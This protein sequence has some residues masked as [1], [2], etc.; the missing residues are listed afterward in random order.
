MM[1]MKMIHNVM[2][3]IRCLWR[4][5]HTHT[6][7]HTHTV[8]LRYVACSV[9]IVRSRTKATELVGTALIRNPDYKSPHRRQGVI[10]SVM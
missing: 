5:T 2:R 7:T 8:E 1:A 3:F 10:G 6:H 9:G 4:V